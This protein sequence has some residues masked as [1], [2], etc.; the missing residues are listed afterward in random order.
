MMLQHKDNFILYSY[1]IVVDPGTWIRF[2]GSRS[3]SKDPDPYPYPLKKL[4]KDPD[5]DPSD[6]WTD[7]HLCRVHVPH[8]KSKRMYKVC[9]NKFDSPDSLGVAVEKIIDTSD[10]S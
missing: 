10:K 5:L 3:K 1:K 7:P 9:K 2:Y 4:P 8:A 6:F